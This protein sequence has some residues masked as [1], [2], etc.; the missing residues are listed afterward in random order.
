MPVPSVPLIHHELTFSSICSFS[1][2]FLN[3]IRRFSERNKLV[4]EAVFNHDTMFSFYWRKLFNFQTK[5]SDMKRDEFYRL[6]ETKFNKQTMYS[7]EQTPLKKQKLFTKGNWQ[8][9]RRHRGINRCILLY[10][11]IYIITTQVAR[12]VS[13]GRYSVRILNGAPDAKTHVLIFLKSLPG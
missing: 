12:G 8:P 7:S 6:N 4:L 10:I 3:G 9:I 11:Y 5:P 13:A 2:I 1:H